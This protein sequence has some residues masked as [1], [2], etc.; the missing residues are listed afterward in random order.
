VLSS[1]RPN[2]SHMNE[3]KHSSTANTLSLPAFPWSGRQLFSDIR[4]ALAQ[5]HAAVSTYAGLGDIMGVPKTTAYRW[6][7][8]FEHPNIIGLFACLERLP[9]ARRQHLVD[10][11]CRIFA[12]FEHPW[13][14]HSPARVGKML[15][16]LN[17]KRG[18]TIMAG[19]QELYRSFL[20]NAFGNACHRL[21]A[22]RRKVTAL[23]LRPPDHVVPLEFC[24]YPDGPGLPEVRRTVLTLWPRIVTTSAR[25]VLL[26]GVWPMQD[27]RQ[28]ILRLA[29][30]THVVLACAGAPEVRSIAR[31][32]HTPIHLVTILESKIAKQGI[33][34]NL[35]RVKNANSLTKP[36]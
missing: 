29:E 8:E 36:A 11:H 6:F 24:T 35:R 33:R 1:S 25:I 18:L 16:L 31:E 26:N 12:D 7:Q 3:R 21:H 9:L 10:S 32:V 22:D 13:L 30:R 23:D 5:E 28:D 20:F 15:E 17:K 34:L 19:G 14:S 4:T 27:L 2:K